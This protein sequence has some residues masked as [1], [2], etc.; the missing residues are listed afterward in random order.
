MSITLP[1]VFI[2]QV[3][4]KE[5]FCGKSVWMY[6]YACMS[7]FVDTGQPPNVRIAVDEECMD[8]RADGEETGDMLADLL[9]VRKGIFLAMHN[10][11]R[12]IPNV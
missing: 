8:A 6:N 4:R 11:G 3:M 1:G 5:G 9:K 2:V 10:H 12:A 7:C